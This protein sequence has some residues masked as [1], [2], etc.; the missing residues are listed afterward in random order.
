MQKVLDEAKLKGE[1]NLSLLDGKIKMVMSQSPGQAKSAQEF[2]KSMFSTIIPALMNHPKALA[3]WCSLA[4]SV[5][6]VEERHKSWEIAQDY[7]QRALTFKVAQRKDIGTFDHTILAEILAV[8]PFRSTTTTGSTS[9]AAQ[10]AAA[11]NCGYFNRSGG[12]KYS[13]EE[14]KNKHE[15]NFPGCEDPMNH[16]K[17]SCPTAKAKGGNKTAASTKPNSYVSPHYKG[18]NPQTKNSR[19]VVTK[20]EKG[21]FPSSTKA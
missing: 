9:S 2:A 3:Q 11:V 5:L 1:G 15:C 17:L 20:E 10:S 14:C 7:L 16:N 6:E 19:S 13:D 12:C 4:R 8:R 21:N 18:S